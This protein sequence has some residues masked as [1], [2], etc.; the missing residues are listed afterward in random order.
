MKD[1]E[2]LS[3]DCSENSELDFSLNE[4][5]ELFVDDATTDDAVGCYGRP[6]KRR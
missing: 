4:N 1:L 6:I 5:E 3:K 2:Y